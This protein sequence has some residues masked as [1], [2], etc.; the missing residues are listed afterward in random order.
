MRRRRFFFVQAA[1]MLSA[2]HVEMGSVCV[3]IKIR[4]RKIEFDDGCIREKSFT[5][6]SIS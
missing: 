3:D 4:G 1:L 2:V 5:F 6:P